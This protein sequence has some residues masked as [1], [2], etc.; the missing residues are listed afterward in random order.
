LDKRVVFFQILFL[1][2]FASEFPSQLAFLV[3][4]LDSPGLNKRELGT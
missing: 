1:L 3:L 2:A 4:A